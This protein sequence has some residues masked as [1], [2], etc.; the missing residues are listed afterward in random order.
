MA[1]CTGTS[2]TKQ[3]HQQSRRARQRPG[4][5]HDEDGLYCDGCAQ[6][7]FERNTVYANDIGIEAASE[8]SGELSSNVIIRNNVVYG[9]N[10]AGMT[11]G[12]YAKNGTGGSSNITVVNNTLYNNDLAETG[13]GEF[14][15]Q[16]RATGIVF[17][18]NVVYAGAQGLF[19][20]GYVPGAV[21]PSTTMTTTRRAPRRSSR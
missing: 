19:L 6:V 4:W 1:M 14:Q 18:N 9:S 8:I 21:S 15:I 16:Y 10:S 2:S 7:V 5:R 20:T 3:R 11:V 17:E 12:G 13:S